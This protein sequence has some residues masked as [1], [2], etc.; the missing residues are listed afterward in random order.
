MVECVDRS[1]DGSFLAHFGYNNPNP[2]PIVSPFENRFQPDPPG[3]GQPTV[4]QPGRVTDIFQA[5]STGEPL[6]WRLTG[7]QATASSDSKPCEGTITIFKVL[8]PSTDSGRFNLKID[9]DIAGGASSVGDGGTTG[10]IAVGA[11]QHTVGESAASGTSLADYY[12]SINCVIGATS[13]AQ[14]T[15]ATATVRVGNGQDVVCT[16]TNIRKNEAKAVAPVLECV[17]LNGGVPQQAVWGYRNDND[18]AVPIPI[19]SQNSFTPAPADRGQPDTFEPGSWSGVFTTQFGAASSLAWSVGGQTVSASATSTRCSAVIVLRKVVAPAGD[20]GVFNLRL[21]GNTLATGGNAT[22]A[23]PYTIGVGEAAVSETA[24]PAT[25]LSDYQS[26]IHCT[27]NGAQAVSLTGT[28]ADVPVSNGDFVVCTF[29]NVRHTVPPTPL[30][31]DPVVPSPP[32]AEPPPPAA[33]TPQPP[34]GQA[35]LSV[36]K[37]A[38]PSTAVLGQRITWTIRVTNRSTV[39]STN[40]DVVKVSERSYRT[41]VLSVTPSQGTCT[42]KDCDLGRIPA[43]GSATITVV[44]LATRVRQHPQ[45]RPSRA[46][47]NK[48]RTTSTTRP[49]TWFA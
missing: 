7:N 23:G 16:I 39:D 32:P 33:P 48:S 4:F 36:T 9:G 5:A 19:G 20:P 49:G 2:S 46:P 38:R 35:D 42:L 47:R 11:G 31:P 21:N 22:T 34:N 14:S 26:T 43:G 24:G 44:T 3:R 8:N 13:V 15:S 30:P 40:V 6:T 45:R 28:S 17:V 10:T 1:A 18:F 12:T 29:T 37:T 27:R 41:K 25:N